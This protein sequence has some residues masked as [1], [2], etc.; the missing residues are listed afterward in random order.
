MKYSSVLVSLVVA[1]IDQTRTI[2]IEGAPGVS[3]Y[4]NAFSGQFLQ[5]DVLGVAP[6]N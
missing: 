2:A 1:L 6:K 5:L 4:P 3:P